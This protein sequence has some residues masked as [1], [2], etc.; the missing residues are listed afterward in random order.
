MPLTCCIIV[1]KIAGEH[2][3]PDSC[4]PIAYY[5]NSHIDKCPIDTTGDLW[6][7]LDGSI[8]DTMLITCK[9]DLL[10]Y[11][12]IFQLYKCPSFKCY[13]VQIFIIASTTF[14]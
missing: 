10:S 7:M 3:C 4:F 1:F 14:P 9:G 5:D 2:P 6:T 8:D 13:V 12:L 11:F